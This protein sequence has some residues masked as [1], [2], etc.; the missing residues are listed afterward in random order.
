MLHI[1]YACASFY[2]GHPYQ[3]TCQQSPQRC[4]IY[5]VTKFETVSKWEA[6]AKTEENSEERREGTITTNKKKSKIATEKIVGVKERQV[7]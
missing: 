7:S 2:S 6:V 4:Q 1:R 5:H 3:Y